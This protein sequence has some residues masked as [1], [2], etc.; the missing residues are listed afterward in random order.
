MI[1]LY[2]NRFFATQP[3]IYIIVMLTKKTT[4]V[5]I[6]WGK[7]VCFDYIYDLSHIFC[8]FFYGNL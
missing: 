8:E 3:L 6:K 2:H 7:S 1:R 5:I 4:N